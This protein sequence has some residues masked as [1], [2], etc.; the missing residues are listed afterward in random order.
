MDKRS[1]DYFASPHFFEYKRLKMLVS[2]LYHGF[3]IYLWFSATTTTTTP[4]AYSSN[5]I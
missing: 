1:Y 5:E 2:V 4:V 3:L